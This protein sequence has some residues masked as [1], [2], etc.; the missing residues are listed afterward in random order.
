MEEMS[1]R[2]RNR[3][4]REQNAFENLYAYAKENNIPD[5]KRTAERTAHE[6]HSEGATRP[7]SSGSRASSGTRSKKVPHRLEERTKEQLYERAQELDIEG[8]SQM[9]KDEL[10]DAIRASQ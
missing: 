10:V 6:L 2:E 5:P 7:S 1:F 4:R 3:Q 8:R 9:T